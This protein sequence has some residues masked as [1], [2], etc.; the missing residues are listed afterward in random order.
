MAKKIHS[1][2]TVYNT[3]W[4][5]VYQRCETHW[6]LFFTWLKL[7]TGCLE[8][9]VFRRTNLLSVGDSSLYI[10]SV[11][12]LVLVFSWDGLVFSSFENRFLFSNF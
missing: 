7:K 5:P 2:G 3:Q 4:R 6:G 10:F 8:F 1:D 11:V 12:G 9:D